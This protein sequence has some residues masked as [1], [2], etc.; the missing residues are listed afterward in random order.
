LRGSF[1]CC[2]RRVRGTVPAAGGCGET[3]VF[4]GDRRENKRMHEACGLIW[5][6]TVPFVLR[7]IEFKVGC[8]DP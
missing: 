1:L 8:K 3:F 5:G 6:G 2:C 4:T 7:V